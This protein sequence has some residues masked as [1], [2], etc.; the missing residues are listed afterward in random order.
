MNSCLLK[1]LKLYAI[2]QNKK[3]RPKSSLVYNINVKT[4]KL[5]AYPRSFTLS[6]LTD[7]QLVM[8]SVLSMHLGTHG[9]RLPLRLH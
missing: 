2:H 3:E 6:K 4:Q 5:E 7:Y 8:A 9:K 1:I